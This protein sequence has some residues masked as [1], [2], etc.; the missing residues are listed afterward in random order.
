MFKIFKYL[1]L[2]KLFEKEKKRLVFVFVSI[3][4]LIIFPMIISDFITYKIVDVK[5]ALSIKWVVILGLLFSIS[6]NLY[7]LFVTFFSFIEFQKEN[8]S[9]EEKIK[10]D[11]IL[12]KDEFL[13]RSDTIYQKYK[14]KRE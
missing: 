2:G 4:F 7:K 3:V 5:I 1:L 12:K 10:K 13:S 14:N 6:L 11:K 8:I 9:K